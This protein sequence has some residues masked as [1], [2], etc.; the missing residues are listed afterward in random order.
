[1]QWLYDFH[2]LRPTWL[3]ALIP[4]IL[5]A[6]QMWRQRASSRQWGNFIS[7]H[8]LSYLLDGQQIR[9]QR[10]PIIGILVLWVVTVLAL[11]GPVWSKISV[12]L[13]RNSSAV[14]ICWD[15]SPSMLAEDVKPSRL[16][17][18]RLK[19]IDFLNAKT[20]GQAAL[21]AYSAEAYT[22]T[23]LTDDFQTIVN[24]LPA[25]SPT[26][27]PSVGSN[28]EMALEQAIQLLKDGGVASGDIIMLTDAIAGDAIDTLRNRIQATSH[29][30]TFWGIGSSEGAPIP[31][32]DG[33]FAKNSSG[34]IVVAQLN[35]NDIRQLSR[36]SGA[37]YV[38]L[39]NGDSD[40]ETL[41]ALTDPDASGTDRTE[42]TFEQWREYGQ[43]LPLLLLPF[44]LLFFRRGVVF[45]FLLVP[46]L[47]TVSEQS[48]AMEWED[49]WL[50]PDQQAQQDLASG[51]KEAALRF[52]NPA[53]R[54]LELFKQGRFEEAAKQYRQGESADYDYNLGTALTHAGKYS[55]AIEAFE[56]ALEKRPQFPKAT[57]NLEIARKLQELQQQ[58]QDQQQQDSQ[59]DDQQNS[60]GEQEQQ[61]QQ[62]DSSQ[63]QD[64]EQS[65]QNSDEQQSPSD[66]QEESQSSAQPDNSEQSQ[67]QESNPFATE[68][69]EE[70]TQSSA[71]SSIAAG[72]ES[73]SSATSSSSAPAVS[74]QEQEQP[75]TEEEQKLEQWLRKVPDDPSGLMRNK[76]R[77]Q[78]LQ[79]RQQLGE[80]ASPQQ[81]EAEQRW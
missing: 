12:P 75:L 4:A 69:T 23:P 18:S 36:S 45:A 17:K 5:I 77:Y 39:T 33:G 80:Q 20:D 30:V 62:S 70:Q 71:D 42:Q 67:D 1:M 46:F 37:V 49:L 6:M 32:P 16:I 21:V 7:P 79:R 2:F 40:I 78:Y 43:F 8:L 48:L 50:T 56:K 54:G 24:L 57:E 68:E 47:L 73:S 44:T 41:N 34:N 25:L 19:I 28:P 22:V 60:E 63:Q 38:P 29:D 72:G 64:S 13:E 55:E 74:F 14:V 66:E 53:K 10:W 51:D 58:Q 27:L 65:Q 3:L 26:T 52:S 35:E 31:L 15:L 61:D 59:Q 76:F 9:Q 81:R 11:A